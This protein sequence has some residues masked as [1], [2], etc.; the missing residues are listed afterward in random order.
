MLFHVVWD[1]VDTSEE[2]ERRSLAV[3]AQWQPP[4]PS[5]TPSADRPPARARRPGSQRA[6]SAVCRCPFDE[7]AMHAS[8]HR[9]ITRQGRGALPGTRAGAR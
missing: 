4:E 9:D 7:T 1:F 5:A 8:I 2:G 6:S 3:F